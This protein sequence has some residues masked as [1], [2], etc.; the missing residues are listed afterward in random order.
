MQTENAEKLP[1][2]WDGWKIVDEIGS[3]QFGTVYEIEQNDGWGIKKKAAVKEIK[4][5]QNPGDIR[6]L[7]REGK[8]D[9]DITKTFCQYKDDLKKE[10]E[11]AQV[12]GESEYIVHSDEMREILNEED[13]MSW[14]V[15]IKMELLT[16]LLEAHPNPIMDEETVIQIGIDMCRALEQCKR[17]NVIHRD[18]KPQN[19]FWSDDGTYKLGDFGVAKTV[20]KTIGGTMIGTYKYMAPEVYAHLPYGAS[21]DQYSLGL[22][23]YWLL[24]ERRM[25]FEPLPPNGMKITEEENAREKRFSWKNALPEPKHGSPWLKHVVLKACAYHQKDRFEGPRELRKAL[26]EKADPGLLPRYDDEK[27]WK[28]WLMGAGAAVLLIA[29]IVMGI[30]LLGGRDSQEIPVGTWTLQETERT[31]QVGTQSQIKVQLENADALPEDASWSSSDEKIVTV[32]A[33]TGKIVAKAAGT[34]VIT[35]SAG[36]QEEQ[37]VVNVVSEEG[38]HDNTVRDISL[39]NTEL[40]LIVGQS[41][42]LSTIPDLE[43][44]TV[45]WKTKNSS[46]ASVDNSGVVT[47]LTEG[48]TEIVA[49]IGSVS[50]KCKLTVVKQEV[51][52]VRLLKAPTKDTYFVGDSIDTAGLKL[53]VS[54]NDGKIEEVSS[55]FSVDY[56][57]SKA[58]KTNVEISYGGQSASFYVDVQEPILS[59]IE[60]ASLPNKTVLLEKTTL[61]VSGLSVRLLYNNGEEEIITDGFECSPRVFETLGEQKVH[62]SYKGKTVDF[63]VTVQSKSVVSLEAS[64][65][66]E[67]RYY[68]GDSFDCSSVAVTASY[69]NKTSEVI[70]PGSCDINYDFSTGGNKKITI[71]YGGM[72]TSVS[73]S[74]VAPQIS[75]SKG[76]AGND[77]MQMS[78]STIP[79]SQN[80]NWVSSAPT[81]ATINSNGVAQ[82]KS[83]GNVTITAE[84][85]YAGRKYSTSETL[86]IIKTE[87]KWSEE[88]SSTS[89]P[90]ESSELKIVRTTQTGWGYYH[91]DSNYDGHTNVDSCWVNS[92][93]NYCSIVVSAPLEAKWICNDK[94]GRANEEYKGPNCRCYANGTGHEVWW[95]DSALDAYVYYYKTLEK[96]SKIVFK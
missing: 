92:S 9:A 18:V 64:I 38:Q 5:P 7:R 30:H 31:M 62:V 41:A 48:T 96:A 68:I 54:F 74:V 81:I 49:S 76:T 58:G 23:L 21:A 14:K 84:F 52:N 93:S 77:T 27:P 34:A 94:G 39:N 50:A 42:I 73:V 22:V 25:P 63:S 79:S 36:D 66:G 43:E 32:D 85:T 86:S 87:E 37:C 59:G 35:L 11:L 33:S 95:H 44:D 10:Y 12:L 78:A 47:A 2:L 57:F 71:S 51:E 75:I 89:K 61:D 60:I 15:L 45:I 17:K 28:R 13:K 19:I 26:E 29:A 53:E 55:G 4:I 56:D 46:I 8:S 70:S 20:E 88:K 65:T 72:T 91:Y 82:A 6:N 69:D 3:G 80:I 67:N 24:N 16:P 90:T 83:T 40:T 1:E